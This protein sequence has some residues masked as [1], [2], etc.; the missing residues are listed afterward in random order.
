MK[1]LVHLRRGE[2][3]PDCTK[4]HDQPVLREQYGCDAPAA[5]TVL[6]VSCECR[7]GCERCEK[8]GGVPL[9]RCPGKLTEGRSDLRAALFYCEQYEEQAILPASG[10]L[11]D[12]TPGFLDLLAVYARE[13]EHLRTAATQKEEW[14]SKRLMELKMS[15]RG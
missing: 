10:G 13:R 7:S 14:R 9:Y 1:A 3:I 15:G 11:A 2:K 5:R 4:C 8:T 12:Q 6:T